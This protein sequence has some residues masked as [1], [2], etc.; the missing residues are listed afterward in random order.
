MTA[1]DIALKVDQAF[2][3]QI[4]ETVRISIWNKVTETY[5]TVTQ[6]DV[7]SESLLQFVNKQ[8]EAINQT[9]EILVQTAQIGTPIAD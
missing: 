4:G 7:T 2:S 6:L 8:I 3:P 5:T 1:H 9:H